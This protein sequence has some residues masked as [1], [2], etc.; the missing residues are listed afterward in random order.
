MG[1]SFIGSAMEDG[2]LGGPII[3]LERSSYAPIEKLAQIRR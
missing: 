3:S 2:Q 1:N